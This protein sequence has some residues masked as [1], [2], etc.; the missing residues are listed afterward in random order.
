M[1]TSTS[2]LD[3]TSTSSKPASNQSGGCMDMPP[4]VKEHAWLRRFEGDWTTEGEIHMHPGQPPM[5]VTGTDRCRMIG[6]FWLVCEGRGDQMNFESRLTLGYDEKIRKYVGTWIDS[7]TSYLWHYV[8]TVD[9]A[10]RILV[11]EAEGPS[12][13]DPTKK[14]KFRDVT[15]FKSDNHRVFT[16][17]RLTAD[18]NWVTFL[19]INYRRK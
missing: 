11:L 18:G 8:G 16:A 7:M 10:G 19:T 3:R 5:Q 6:G 13:E 9:A 12:P 2:T 14:A 4:P 1:S 17:S 15:E